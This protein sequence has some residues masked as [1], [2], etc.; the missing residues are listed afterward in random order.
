MELRASHEAGDKRDNR[1]HNRYP[2]EHLSCADCCSRHTAEAEQSCYE[3]DD[4]KDDGPVEKV[5]EHVASVRLSCLHVD[6]TGHGNGPAMN[7]SAEKEQEKDDE[8]N[9]NAD[10]PE[11]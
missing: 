3:S 6:G 8:R 4:Q 9:R 5:A 2:E 10:Q 1:Q 11:K 7:S